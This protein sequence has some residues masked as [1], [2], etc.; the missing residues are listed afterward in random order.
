MRSLANIVFYF[1]C[2]GV[3][4]YAALAY[5][6]FPL[7][8]LVPPVM[9]A[10][11]QAHPIGIYAHI[12]ASIVALVF[13]PFQ[14]SRRL[15]QKNIRLHRWS[16]RAYLLIGVLVGGVAGLYMAQFA[17]GGLTSRV[18]FTLLAVVWLYSGMMAYLAIRR[19]DVE[20]HR[21]WMM[22]NFSLTLAAVTLR[23]YLGLFFAAGLSFEDFYPLLSWLCWVPNVLVTEWF[24]NNAEHKETST[25][26]I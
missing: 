11:F 25:R 12:F 5:G 21:T 3:A 8:S 15:R 13:G 19:H 7:G 1:I 23:C 17:F 2:I 14:F 24:I 4:L 26:S 10:A 6:F 18:G 20:R 16:G 9:K 22:R